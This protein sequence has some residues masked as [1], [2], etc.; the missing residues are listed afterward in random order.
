MGGLNGYMC[1]QREVENYHCGE[2]K[3]FKVDADRNE[4]ICKR[5]DHKV[6]QFGRPFFKSYDC[7]QHAGTICSSFIPA[8]WCKNAIKEWKGFEEYWPNYVEQWLP[9]KNINA[10][11]P[12]FINGNTD[13]SYMVKLM[14]FVNGTM[15]EGNKLKA[16]EKIYYKRDKGNHGCGYKLIKEF[17]DGVYTTERRCGD[18]DGKR[19]RE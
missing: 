3:Y 11:I 1:E 13:I 9:Y 16:K 17:I 5:I 4:S 6:I 19:D 15:L 12:F 2:C 8:A 10:L 14:D 7:N 18:D